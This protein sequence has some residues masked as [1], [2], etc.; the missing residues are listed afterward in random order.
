[1]GGFAL[2]QL[3]IGAL[4]GNFGAVLVRALNLGLFW[5]S[6]LGLI[7]GGAVAFGPGWLDLALDW[8][9]YLGLLAAGGGGMALM[10]IAG[11]LVAWRYA[12]L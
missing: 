11:A 3:L 1:M 10:L 7:G 2:S 8:P 9:W 4:C 12:R 5:N 6:V